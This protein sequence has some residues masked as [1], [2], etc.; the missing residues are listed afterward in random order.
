VVLIEKKKRKFFLRTAS[1][2]RKIY[3]VNNTTPLPF[4]FLLKKRK[5][6]MPQPLPFWFLLKK[7]TVFLKTG[8]M[9]R[10]I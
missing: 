5:F 4:W 8:S 3:E 6:S 9:L 7:R 1:M 2:L 10:K